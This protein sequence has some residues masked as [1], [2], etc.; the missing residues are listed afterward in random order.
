M[1][2]NHDAVVGDMNESAGERSERAARSRTG[3]PPYPTEG[4]AQPA[5]GGRTGST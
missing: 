5:A 1:S 2:E 4:G 3:A